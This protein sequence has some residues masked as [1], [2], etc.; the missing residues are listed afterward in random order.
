MLGQRHLIECHCVLPI[1]KDK[2][3][4]VY[5]KFAVYSKFD[6]KT[7]NVIPKYANCNNCGITHEVYE[8]CRS[9]IIVGK[10]EITSV[11]SLKDI[12]VSLSKKINDILLQYDCAVDVYEEIEDI[13]DNESFPA[14]IILKRE[15]L[16][17]KES[18]KILQIRGHDSMK[19]FSEI[20]DNILI[21]GGE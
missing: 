16:Q 2:K 11:R 13:I 7:G 17:E 15:I 8:L 12:E 9:T 4:T 3:P 5:H 10:E 6:E 20:I 21:S 19:V 14:N 18:V 1:Y